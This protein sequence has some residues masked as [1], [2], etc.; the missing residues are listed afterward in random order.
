MP[1]SSKEELLQRIAELEQQLQGR[2]PMGLEFRV[3]DKV[4][5]AFT[6]LGAF[7]LRFTMNSGCGCW[8][9]Q[10]NY[11]HSSKPTKAS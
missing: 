5:L 11:G 6:A 2:K 10:R 8:T 1:E 4:P 9:M 3:S 7:P